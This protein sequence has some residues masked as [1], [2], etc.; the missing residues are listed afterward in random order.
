MR[1]AN[2]LLPRGRGGRRQGRPCWSPPPTPPGASCYL[3]TH[4]PGQRRPASF[5]AALDGRRQLGA[6][7]RRACR[8][9]GA[10][11]SA[12][13]GRGRS[14]RALE[15][16]PALTD[17]HVFLAARGARR[18]QGPPTR[19]STWRVR[20]PPIPPAPRR[21][22]SWRPWNTSPGARPTYEAGRRRGRSRSIR[23]RRPLPHRR[24][25][26]RPATTAM[27]TR[28]RWRGRAV[29]L[30]PDNPRTQAALGL[31]L[32][33]VGDERGA[34]RALE[35][36][37]RADAYDLV[38]V[39]PA[40]DARHAR[41][42][43]VDRGRAPSPSSSIPTRRRRLRHLRRAAGEGRHGA[44]DASATASSRR[45]RS[46]SRSS[47]STTTSP[48]ARSAFRAC[49]A[50]SAPA[51]AAWSRSTRRARGQPG[52]FNWQATLWHEMAHVFTMQLSKYRVPRWL[53][54]GISG[55]RGRPAA[56]RMGPRL[57]AGVRQGVGRQEDPARS[58]SSTAGLHAPGHDRTG[59]LPGVAGGVA[60]REGSTGT[61][62]S[63]RCCARTATA[64]T[65]RPRS[66]A[67]TGRGSADL[68]R[69]FD[70][71]LTERYAA[72]GKALQAP[73][74]PGRAARRRRA[75]PIKALAA[76]HAGSYPVQMAAGQALRGAPAPARTPSRRSSARP[77]LVPLGGRAPRARA[78]RS[79]PSPSGRAT[80]ARRCAN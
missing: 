19:R 49:S 31:H 68:Q 4:D 51:S 73:D 50:P 40:P 67:P 2:A 77:A 56:A 75:R 62:R 33:R 17:A 52:S 45:A 65:P 58:P 60:H 78:P 6:G 41:R 44:D 71:M 13:G 5:R 32:L 48:S 37:F 1:T 57:R 70:A 30:E 14:G 8:G 36:A 55:L 63:T 29:A 3:D 23:V 26:T 42:V 7:P 20:W 53:T 69:D 79:R 66:A 28:W 12:R 72:V 22:R 24:R 38:D 74:G 80:S 76:K 15:I 25:R 16:D 46:W 43:R 11:G 35:T 61:P 59:V 21:T 64:R 34:R 54:E 9:P 27:T 47:R 10:R 18:R 39:Q